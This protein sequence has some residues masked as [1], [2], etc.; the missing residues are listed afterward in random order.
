MLTDTASS[1]DTNVIK[2]EAEKILDLTIEI[3]RML[4]VKPKVI[5]VPTGAN[6]T[7]SKSFGQ[8]M[9]NVPGKHEIKVLQKTA[10][11]GTA[12][13]HTHTHTHCVKC[14]VKEQNI[15]NMRN[16]IT[17]STDC[18]YGTAATL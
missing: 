16:N 7:V 18:K 12:H 14:N 10:I 8:Y 11:M 2:K 13:T 17:C 4:H 9:S 6:G 3:Q 1:G 15:F 5:P